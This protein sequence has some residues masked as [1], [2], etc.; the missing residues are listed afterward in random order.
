MTQAQGFATTQL[1]EGYTPGVPQFTVATPVYQSSAYVF[2]SLT[3]ARE[4]FALR[5]KGYIYSRNN[6][7][8]Q[9]VLEQ[10]LAALEGGVAAA[11]V[12]SGQAAVALATLA[13][14]GRGG[15][16]VAASQLYGGTVDLFDDTL[17]DFGLEVTFVDQ[18]DFDGWR[19]AVR[20]NTRAF[21][22]ESVANPIAQVLDV[23]SVAEIAHEAGVPLVIDN[24][25]ATPYLL[26][27]REHG[28]DIVVH[29]ATKFIGGHGSSLGGV[30]VDLGTFDFAAE[31][32]R[33]PALFVPHRRYGEVSLWEA[34]GPERAFITLVKSKLVGDLGP[35]LSPFNAFQLIQGL[36][37]LDLRVSRHVENAKTVAA[38]LHDHPA[39]GVVFHP[40]IPTNPWKGVARTYLPR[41]APS[42]FA[43]E[44]APSEEDAFARA[45][46][47]IDALGTIRLVANIGDART[48]VAHPASMTH[49][50]MSPEQLA[51]AGI[52]QGTIRISVGLEDPA[53]IIADL[54]QALALA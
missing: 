27:P 22:A 33:W 36:E 6:N 41:G 35:A 14:L 30:V 15:H 4:K 31:P 52:S 26:R 21:F 8:T 18:D 44:L 42:V 50:H 28:A 1:H 7:P 13:L 54:A 5:E 45:E 2:S 47:V 23:A 12:S 51:A 48:I 20:P 34:F 32:E 49:N 29:S 11:A 37:T 3:E 53:D 24:T 39:V 10:R 43:F 40:S 9:A 19:E 25:V 38:F 46:R 16:V 17:R